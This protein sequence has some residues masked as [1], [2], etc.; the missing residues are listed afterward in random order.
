MQSSH[1]FTNIAGDIPGA[2]MFEAQVKRL[3]NIPFC[4][5]QTHALQ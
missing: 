1:V 2:E 5:T 4:G 3:K